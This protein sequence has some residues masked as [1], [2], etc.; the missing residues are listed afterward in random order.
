MLLKL[1]CFTNKLNILWFW[2]T[3]NEKKDDPILGY[4]SE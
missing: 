4:F 2:E 1:N 3:D